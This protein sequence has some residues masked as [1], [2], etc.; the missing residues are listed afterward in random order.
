[1]LRISSRLAIC[2]LNGVDFMNYS[3]FR[4]HFCSTCENFG[5]KMASL[6]KTNVTIQIEQKLAVHILN[7]K[8][9]LF[10]QIFGENT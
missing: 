1:V 10:R 5:V 6:S 2:A 9:A 4:S 8:M 3:K 7:K